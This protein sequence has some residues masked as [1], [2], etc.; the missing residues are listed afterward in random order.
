MPKL[1]VVTS[2][3]V[4]N[5]PTS[6]FDQAWQIMPP[7]MRKRSLGKVKLRPIWAQHAKLFGGEE[8]LLNALRAYV[9]DED[10]KKWGGK[11]LDRWLRDGRYE[12]YCQTEQAAVYSLG[13]KLPE[14]YRSALVAECGEGWVVSYVDRCMVEGTVLVIPD[15]PGKLTMLDKIKGQARQMKS[16]GL[17]AVRLEK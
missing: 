16:A 1:T 11:A 17:T 2:E 14:P 10:C 8:N 15:V 5:F 6:L 4:V 3:N 13:P 7:T 12:H 9:Q